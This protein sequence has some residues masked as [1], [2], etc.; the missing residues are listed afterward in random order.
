MALIPTQ[1]QRVLAGLQNALSG[2]TEDAYRARDAA[3]ERRDP[4]GQ[5]YAAGEAHGYA[6]SAQSVRDA[7]DEADK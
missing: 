6:D 5:T 3:E 2:K 7:Q 4:E 1:L